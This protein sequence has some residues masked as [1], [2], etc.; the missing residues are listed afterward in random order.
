MRKIRALNKKLKETE[1]PP[2]N[3]FPDNI[4]IERRKGLADRR[5]LHTYIANDRRSGIIDRRK[6][7]YKQK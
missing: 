7:S 3:H 5:R 1:D 2:D 6:K 4:F